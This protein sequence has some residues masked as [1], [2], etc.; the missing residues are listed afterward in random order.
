MKTH[1]PIFGD[2]LASLEAY[3]NF[4]IDRHISYSSY[5]TKV[6]REDLE[7]I[8]KCNKVRLYTPTLDTGYFEIN[9]VEYKLNNIIVQPAPHTATG[10]SIMIDANRPMEYGTSLTDSARKKLKE[11]IE[12]P[13]VDFYKNNIRALREQSKEDYLQSIE[14]DLQIMEENIAKTRAALQENGFKK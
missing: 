3:K 4:S 5:S 14:K 8:E 2:M 6:I 1:M 13:I 10:Y 12:A 11:K 7:S 9:S